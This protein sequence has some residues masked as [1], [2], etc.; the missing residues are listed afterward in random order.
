MTDAI[1]IFLNRLRLER[2]L[3]SPLKVPSDRLKKAMEE[4]ENNELVR[5]DAIED[6]MNDLKLWKIFTKNP[7]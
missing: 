7:G 6:M 1:N 3:F 5:Y 2:G 4:A